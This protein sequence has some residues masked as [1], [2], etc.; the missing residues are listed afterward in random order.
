MTLAVLLLGFLKE[1]NKK[2]VIENGM[3]NIGNYAFSYCWGITSITIPNSVTSI[4]WHAFYG[5]KW[6]KNRPYGMDYLGRV[7]YRF[8][9]EMPAILKLL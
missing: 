5:T 9:G 8:N 6:A 3:K 2:V 7:L 4:G 1:I